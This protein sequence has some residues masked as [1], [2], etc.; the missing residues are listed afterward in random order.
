MR[1]HISLTL[2]LA[3]LL[4][5][6]VLALSAGIA[7]A[8]GLNDATYAD[9][10]AA[11]AGEPAGNALFSTA[12]T[13]LTEGET[14]TAQLTVFGAKTAD[15]IIGFEIPVYYDAERLTPVLDRLDGD[16]L[17]CFRELPGKNWENLTSPTVRTKDGLSYVHVQCGTAKTDYFGDQAVLNCRL[18]FVRNTDYD[19]AGIWLGSATT[20]CFVDDDMLTKYPGGNCYALAR[21]VPPYSDE[22]AAKVGTYSG[23]KPFL[24]TAELSAVLYRDTATATVTCRGMKSADKVIGFQIP[25]YYDAE[26]LEPV[27]TDLD[28]D[29]LNCLKDGMPG[30]N[31]ENLTPAKVFESEDGP[32]VYLQCGTAKTDYCKDGGDLVFTVTFRLKP[33]CTQAGL[34]TP[35]G[36]T[37]CFVDDGSMTTYPGQA[38]Y[39][40]GE[41]KVQ[42]DERSELPAD[43]FLIDY[44]GYAA[45]SAV[46]VLTG[47]G[48][49]VAELT[50]RGLGA[51][52]NLSDAYNLLVG[53]DGKVLDVDF[54]LGKAC[55]FVCPKGGYILSW[56]VGKPGYEALLD[57]K[58]GSEVTLYNVCLDGVDA[59]NGS[60]GLTDAGFTFVVQQFA[61]GD[62][63]GDGEVDSKDYFQLKKIIL[64]TMEIPEGWE[65][66]LDV[67]GDGEWDAKDYIYLKKLVLGTI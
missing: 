52:K 49:T 64:G 25:L 51:E 35:S 57:L 46:S 22:I 16:A 31:W 66:R 58:K 63:N 23:T 65:P 13:A 21:Y 59:L 20:R 67:N 50:R 61:L 8:E 9:D 19:T 24:Y 44:A 29:A 60:V 18:S 38:A 43:A 27:L 11:L 6:A 36:R 10:L 37:A 1:K 26:R 48:E 17:D 42:P 34:W 56:S 45:D 39:A 40:V 28:G 53:P 5:A 55:S 2:A 30:K 15:K 47:D 12:L 3:V 4:T 14:V 41:I 62:I 54:E 33:G 7:E 32:Y